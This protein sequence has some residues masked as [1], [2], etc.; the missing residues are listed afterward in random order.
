MDSLI[1]TGA[2]GIARRAPRELDA[3]VAISSPSG[4]VGGAEEAIALCIAL[5]P[6][7]ADVQRVPCSTP[8]SA[9]DLVATVAGTGTR[10]D[11][12]AR[13]RRHGDR[14]TTPTRRCAAT[15][16]GCTAPALPI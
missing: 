7:Q 10:P 8:G 11:D 2:A 16:T 5:L 12:A 6:E 14:A 13:P 1:E 3:L 15:A 4:D 9:A